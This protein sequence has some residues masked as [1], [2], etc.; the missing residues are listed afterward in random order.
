MFKSQ[1]STF[2]PIGALLLCKKAAQDGSVYLKRALLCGF[3]KCPF[4][5]SALFVD[6]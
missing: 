3:K 5:C 4:H 2:D 6:L 1:L